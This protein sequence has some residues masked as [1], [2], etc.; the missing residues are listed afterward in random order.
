MKKIIQNIKLDK[1]AFQQKAGHPRTEY[2]DTLSAP[3]TLALARWPWYNE[4]DLEDILNTYLNTKKMNFLGQ[5]FQKSQQY[6]HTDRD[7]RTHAT[8]NITRVVKIL[9]ENVHRPIRGLFADWHAVQSQT[10]ASQSDN[11]SYTYNVCHVLGCVSMALILLCNPL[12]TLRIAPRLS[13][14]LSG[15]C[16][17]RRNERL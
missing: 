10:Y 16:S 12:C 14:R 9:T 13:V 7:T 6:K 2:T 17:C 3:V 11:Y 1:I 8:K 5:R 15:V 4:F